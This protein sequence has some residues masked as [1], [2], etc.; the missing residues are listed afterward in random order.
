MPRQLIG[1]RLCL[2]LGI[3]FAS[4]LGAQTPAGTPAFNVSRFENGLLP[5]GLIAG[6]PDPTFGIDERMRFW[7]V[8]G[9]SV[10]VIDNFRIVYARGFGVTEFGGSV[11][12][13][14]TTLFQAGSI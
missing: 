12:V 9:I 7:N 8:P 1:L 2:A 6:K 5:A 14:T 11:A 10:A 13:D 3:A 4:S